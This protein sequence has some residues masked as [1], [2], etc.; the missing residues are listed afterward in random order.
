MLTVLVVIA[1]FL[2]IWRYGVV[3]PRSHDHGLRS[4]R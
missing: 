3:R 4:G 1:L 2:G